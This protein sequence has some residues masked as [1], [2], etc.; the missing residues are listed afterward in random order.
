MPEMRPK[1]E[2]EPVKD[3]WAMLAAAII[4]SGVKAGDERFLESG[5]C[6]ELRLL[7]RL[8]VERDDRKHEAHSVSFFNNR[9]W[10]T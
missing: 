3:G 7:V 5:W 9:V 2:S 4:D 1:K 6:E 10:E 8:S